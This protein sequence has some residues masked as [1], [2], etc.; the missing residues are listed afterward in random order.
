M[1]ELQQILQAFKQ[2]QQVGKRMVLATVV[3]TS[4][5]VYRR[6]GARM[7][8]TEDG[9]MISAINGG[10]LEAD[11]LERSRPLLCNNSNPTLVRYNTTSSDDII[12]GFGMGCNGIVDVLLE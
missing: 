4:G 7:L 12:F 6:P 5:S 11:I 8:I 3:Q 2:S 10:C 9:R 1:N